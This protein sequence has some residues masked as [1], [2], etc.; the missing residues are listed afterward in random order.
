MRSDT[1]TSY[2]ATNLQLDSI[3]IKQHESLNAL[4]GKHLLIVSQANL[5]QP[6]SHMITS[7]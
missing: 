5:H 1:N 2:E 7:P 6:G 4:V 3:Q